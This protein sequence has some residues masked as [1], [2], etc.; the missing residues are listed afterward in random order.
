MDGWMDEWAENGC[1]FAGPA[2]AP[3]LQLMNTRTN[4]CATIIV[5]KDDPSHHHKS[6]D[7]AQ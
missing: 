7:N 1:A 3:G 6:Y 2:P 5:M 4:I